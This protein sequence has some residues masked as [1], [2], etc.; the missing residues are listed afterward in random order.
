MA[1]DQFVFT[2]EQQRVRAAIHRHRIRRPR[3]LSYTALEFFDNGKRIAP[4][5]PLA[6]LRHLL[7][8][9][10]PLAHSYLPRGLNPWSRARSNFACFIALAFVVCFAFTPSGVRTE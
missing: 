3:E 1:A 7:Q 9:V 8:S 6:R 2:A 5:W 10:G 4:R